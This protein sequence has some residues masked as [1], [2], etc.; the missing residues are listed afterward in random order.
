MVTE[1]QT[2]E[3]RL[4][5]VRRRE[6]QEQ[7]DQLKLKLRAIREERRAAIAEH[8]RMATA[9]RGERAAKSKIKL[10]LEDVAD[11]IAASLRMRPAAADYLD[12]ADDPDIEQW[13]KAHKA[14]EAEHTR[15]R[16]ESAD[17]AETAVIDAVRL[18]SRIEQ[19][20]FEERATMVQIDHLAGTGA[21][22]GHR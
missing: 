1:A 12:P 8:E 13:T 18:Q 5:D 11:R 22:G 16:K 10:A 7:A 6:Q 17:L 15:L 4:A 21:R 2:L 3:I 19:L 9:I 14:L 20:G